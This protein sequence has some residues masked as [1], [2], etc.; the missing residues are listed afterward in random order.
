MG[1]TELEGDAGFPQ[2]SDGECN[3]RFEAL[4]EILSPALKLE[5]IAGFSESFCISGIFINQLALWSRF[6]R[7]INGQNEFP[8]LTSDRI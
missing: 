1:G 4:L 6:H 8:V 2:R 3:Q 7:P 5:R